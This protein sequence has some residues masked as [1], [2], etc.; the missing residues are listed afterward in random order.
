MMTYECSNPIYGRTS[1]P[2]DETRGPGGSSGGEGAIIGAKAS[3][4]GKSNPHDV[5]IGPGAPLGKGGIIRAK[6]SVSNQFYSSSHIAQITDFLEFL[7]EYCEEKS[8]TC[9]KF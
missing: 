4:M 3:V 1:N 9:T 8:E 7:H 2:H 6:A 5:T